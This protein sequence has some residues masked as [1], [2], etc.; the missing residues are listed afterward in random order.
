MHSIDSVDL[1]D[2]LS[3]CLARKPPDIKNSETAAFSQ[4][5]CSLAYA[6]NL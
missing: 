6:W 2:G 4:Q 5:G 3:C 1:T